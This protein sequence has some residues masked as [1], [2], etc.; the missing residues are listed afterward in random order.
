MPLFD[1]QAVRE[2][3]W[4]SGVVNTA[5]ATH[6]AAVL[7]YYAPGGLSCC[8]IYG[9]R[10]SYVGGTLTGGRLTIADGTVVFYDEDISGTPE[11]EV[12][13]P[14]PFLALPGNNIVITLADGGAS[15][16]GKLSGISPFVAVTYPPELIPTLNFNNPANSGLIPAII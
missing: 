15:V 3:V 1:P 4:G 12:V 10:W 13:F 16:V 5:T 2:F 6:G 9:V 8:G 11:G 14:S 7:T